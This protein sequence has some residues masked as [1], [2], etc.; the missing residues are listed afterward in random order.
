ML[1][2]FWRSSEFNNTEDYAC[3]M[4]IAGRFLFC[5]LVDIVII[6]QYA[7]NYTC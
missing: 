2:I 6:A 5:I 7:E 1:I 4:E 3:E